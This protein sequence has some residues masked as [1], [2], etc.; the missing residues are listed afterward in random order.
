[1]HIEAPNG[2]SQARD[3][4]IPKTALRLDYERLDE[5]NEKDA[6]LRLRSGANGKRLLTAAVRKNLHM[7]AFDRRDGFPG[8]SAARDRVHPDRAWAWD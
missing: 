2:F 7:I 4:N 6:D 3:N 1:M 5:W 8:S